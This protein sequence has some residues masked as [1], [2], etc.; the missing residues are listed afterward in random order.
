MHNGRRTCQNPFMSLLGTVERPHVMVPR[1]TQCQC[2]VPWA[3]NRRFDE[4]GTSRSPGKVTT[5]KT[6]DLA[7]DP[8]LSPNRRW[9]ILPTPPANFIFFRKKSLNAFNKHLYSVYDRSQ[10]NVYYNKI[11]NFFDVG[12]ICRTSLT[13]DGHRGFRAGTCSRGL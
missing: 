11:L 4:L 1:G 12:D 5:W 6:A 9:K 3:C 8:S 13:Y 7:P 2:D 10:P